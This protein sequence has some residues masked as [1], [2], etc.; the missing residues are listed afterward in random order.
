MTLHIYGSSRS[1]TRRVLW[2]ALELGVEFEQRSLTIH[3]AE[4]KQDEYLSINPFGR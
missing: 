2:A 3:D 4:I 1:R